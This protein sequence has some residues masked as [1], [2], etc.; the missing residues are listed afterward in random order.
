[1][2]FQ[3][4]AAGLRVEEAPTVYS[5]RNHGMSQFALTKMGIV[6]ARLAARAWRDQRRARPR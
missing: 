2:V 3:A 6:Y 4:A 1:M 5:F